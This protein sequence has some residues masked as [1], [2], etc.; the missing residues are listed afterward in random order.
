MNV[1]GM[2]CVVKR[3]PHKVKWEST[4]AQTV[5]HQSAIS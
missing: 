2:K 1:K 4:E 3:R 5:S